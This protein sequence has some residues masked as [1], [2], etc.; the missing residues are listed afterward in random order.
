MESFFIGGTAPYIYDDATGTGGVRPTVEHVTRI[1]RIAEASGAVGGMGRAVKLKD[2]VEQMN[3]M[4]EHCSK[5]LYFAVTNDA[6]LERA[7]EIQ[8]RQVGWILLHTEFMSPATVVAVERLLRQ[9]GVVERIE[10]PGGII[11]YRF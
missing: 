3:L 5:P 7:R 6:A 8:D 11:A 10:D 2:E 9:A 4:V 1:A